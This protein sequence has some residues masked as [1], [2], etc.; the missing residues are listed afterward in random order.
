MCFSFNFFIFFS[1]QTIYSSKP[2][3]F[4]EMFY[5]IYIVYLW[6]ILEKLRYFLKRSNFDT[7]GWQKL[8]GIKFVVTRPNLIAEFDH[9]V[10]FSL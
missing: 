4:D 6:G 8:A 3:I 2:F 1:F 10:T 9:V 5:L 7:V